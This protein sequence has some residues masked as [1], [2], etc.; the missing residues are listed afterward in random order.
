MEQTN[1]VTVQ[2]LPIVT[3]ARYN[4]ADEDD[5]HQHG[6]TLRRIPAL[7]DDKVVEGLL[8]ELWS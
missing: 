6:D 8:D 3:T 2:K 7:Q 5:G 1:P 4:V